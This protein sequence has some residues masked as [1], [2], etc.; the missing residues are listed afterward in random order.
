MFSLPKSTP[1]I[2]LI[3]EHSASI[4]FLRYEL[5]Q[6]VD[7]KIPFTASCQ[8]KP[9]HKEPISTKHQTLRQN[10]CQLADDHLERE[11]NQ[12]T[13]LDGHH[14]AQWA[15]F[16]EQI[17]LAGVRYPLHPVRQRVLQIPSPSLMSLKK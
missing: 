16:S 2:N 9:S 5:R 11:T 17:L 13:V 12:A 7:I 6:R 15:T 10:P 3:L 14:L 8:A 4:S 1:E